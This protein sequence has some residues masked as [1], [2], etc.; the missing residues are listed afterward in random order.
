MIYRTRI[1]ETPL[2]PMLA[3]S[4]GDSLVGLEFQDRPE[5]VGRAR[6]RLVAHAPGAAFDDGANDDVLRTTAS[7][8]AAYFAGDLA[9]LGRIPVAPVGTPF[10]L[11]TWRALVRIPA[12]ATRSYADLARAV[13][14]PGASRAVGHANG[15]NSIALVLPCHRVVTSA[16]TLGGYGGGLDKKRWLLAHEGAPGFS[17]ATLALEAAGAAR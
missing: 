4:N 1:L 14:S 6:A 7:A 15:T 3:I 8:L 12:G 16:G 10:Q 11:R 2:A 9:A 13:G 5:R 17:G